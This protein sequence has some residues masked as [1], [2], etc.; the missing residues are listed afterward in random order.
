MGSKEIIA[1]NKVTERMLSPHLRRR[2]KTVKKTTIISAKVDL[3]N[4]DAYT[5]GEAITAGNA[6]HIAADGLAYKADNSNNKPANGFAVNDVIQNDTV[7][8]LTSRRITVSSASFTV[9][10]KVFLSSG[11]INVTT[12]IPT[13]ANNN[14]LQR[15]DTAV[16]TDTAQIKIEEV[17]IAQL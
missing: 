5:A 4:Y 6:V 15:L 14:I 12:T 7:Y 1:T 16:S 9:G 2:S 17:R 3:S 11:T 10:N 13:L 8:I